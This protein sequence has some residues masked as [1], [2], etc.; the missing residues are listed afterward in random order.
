MRTLV[1]G[2]NVV[3]AALTARVIP[4]E[5]YT[6]EGGALVERCQAAGSTVVEVSSSVLEAISTLHGK[7]VWVE[8]T[9]LVIPGLNDGVASVAGIAGFLRESLELD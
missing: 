3:S 4:V 9:T 6:V 7:G 1:E 5:V 8:V 2:P